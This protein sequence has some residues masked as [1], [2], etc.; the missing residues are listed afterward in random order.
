[1]AFI[2]ITN[3]PQHIKNRIRNIIPEVEPTAAASNPPLPICGRKVR[4]GLNW[5]KDRKS[6]FF[7][8]QMQRTNLWRAHEAR[9]YK[10]LYLKLD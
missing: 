9:L 2:Y 8:R 7:L 1:M 3:L 6:I 10:L 4:C 5:K